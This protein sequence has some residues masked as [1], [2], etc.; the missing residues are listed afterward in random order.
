M[1]T[2]TQTDEV[3]DWIIFHVDV[4]HTYHLPTDRDDAPYVATIALKTRFNSINMNTTV[5]VNMET[6]IALNHVNS[7]PK[8]L[9]FPEMVCFSCQGRDFIL[10]SSH[11]DLS[12]ATAYGKE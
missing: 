4:S 9:T 2:V 5:N 7:S 6:R 11:K 12:E 8:L 10:A 3:D 1:C